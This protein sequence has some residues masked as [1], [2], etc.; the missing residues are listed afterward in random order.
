MQVID[1][2]PSANYRSAFY[3]VQLE[4]GA[5][6]HALNLNII[7]NDSS[8]NYV[9][10]GDVYNFTPLGNF[11]VSFSN[12]TI[13]VYLTPTYAQTYV[14]YTKN[15]VKKLDLLAAPTGDLGLVSSSAG[16]TFDSG[17]DSD[18]VVLTYDY[19]YAA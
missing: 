5:Q 14:T 1:S 7:N 12:N 4:T 15:L 19:G 2:F 13:Y 16:V 3:Q 11:N 9:T 6:Y 18:T 17:Y 8:A 10:Y